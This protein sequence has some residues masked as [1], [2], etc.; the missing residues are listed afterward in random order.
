MPSEQGSFDKKFVCVFFLLLSLRW[1]H[2][3]SRCCAAHHSCSAI[4]L[5]RIVWDGRRLAAVRAPAEHGVSSYVS[6]IWEVV[7]DLYFPSVFLKFPSV[8]VL[9]T[10][11]QLTEVLQIT[12]VFVKMVVVF[13]IFL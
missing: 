3:Y 8:V 11:L 1:R 4:N 13:K 5:S 2:N 7:T 12:E 10:K 6:L 9:K